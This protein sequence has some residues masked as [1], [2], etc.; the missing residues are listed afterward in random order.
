MAMM[1][2]IKIMHVARETKEKKKKTVVESQV[3]PLTQSINIVK[4][5]SNKERCRNKCTKNGGNY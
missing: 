3:V 2:E 5:N 4:E 1:R